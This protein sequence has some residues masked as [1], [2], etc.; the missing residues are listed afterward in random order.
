MAVVEGGGA[1][2]SRA[3][4]P[5]APVEDDDDEVQITGRSGDLALVDFP[6]SREFCVT[7]PFVL[8]KE[9]ERCANCYCYVCD[10]LASACPEWACKGMHCQ[11]K[12]DDVK[13]QTLRGLW[14]AHGGAPPAG[15]CSSA[16][17]AG[18][19]SNAAEDHRR[20]YV[21]RL[22]CDEFLD[23]IQ[24]VYPREEDE[25]A[26]F[27]AAFKLRP[28][29]RQS[30]AYMLDVERS[31]D[32]S[33][34]G[35][36]TPLRKP[37]HGSSRYRRFHMDTDW[38]AVKHSPDAH[39]ARGG[40]LC[41]EVGSNAAVPQTPPPPLLLARGALACSRRRALGSCVWQWARRP[42]SR[43]SSSPTPRPASSR[44][45]TPTSAR[46]SRMAG[47]ATTLS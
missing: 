21:T 47:S 14:K 8:G 31:T 17:V 3:I 28:Y 30:L 27:P 4:V 2:G 5:V 24:Q 18:G 9:S 16:L 7:K 34:V 23:R 46:C 45:T 13:W 38:E 25:P 36:R 15:G 19:G 32:Q 43:R 37:D 12:H 26:G 40:W 6:H 11:A 44:S 42:L 22:T 35:T 29:Q 39:P 20:Q 33:L 10:Q 41:D 1:G